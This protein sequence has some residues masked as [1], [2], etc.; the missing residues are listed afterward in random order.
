MLQSKEIKCLRSCWQ[1][2]KIAYYS[3]KLY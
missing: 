2:N 3:R 1:K